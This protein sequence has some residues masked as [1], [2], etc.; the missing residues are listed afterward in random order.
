[1]FMKKR[2]LT[3]GLAM[4]SLV[5]SQDVKLD[6]LDINKNVVVL[7]DTTKKVKPTTTSVQC[8][9]TSKSTN[10]RCKLRT[11][12]VSGFCHHHRD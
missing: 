12:D 10:N 6:S 5:F 8:A 4:G 9:G 2:F 1:M 7:Q 3:I 11:K